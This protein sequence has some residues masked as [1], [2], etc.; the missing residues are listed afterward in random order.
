MLF[1]KNIYRE[2]FINSEIGIINNI[3]IYILAYVYIAVVDF[4]H[5]LFSGWDPIAPSI[6]RIIFNKNI[7]RDNFVLERNW[8]CANI[9]G[10]RKTG[11]RDPTG[12][13]NSIYLISDI[14]IFDGL[15]YRYMISLL[16]WLTIWCVASLDPDFGILKWF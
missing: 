2:Y 10:C 9:F 1:Y 15:S 13:L 11:W 14:L 3:N 12:F 8:Y 7:Y 5:F 4:S 6:K 16:S